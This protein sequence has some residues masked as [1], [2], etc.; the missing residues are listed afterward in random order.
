MRRRRVLRADFGR[1]TARR[2]LLLCIGLCFMLSLIIE[3]SQAW[4]PS[5][6]SQVLDLLLNTLGGAVGVAVQRW[7]HHRRETRRRPLQTLIL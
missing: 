5:R 6:S 7:H 3:L 2:N 1:A 4:I